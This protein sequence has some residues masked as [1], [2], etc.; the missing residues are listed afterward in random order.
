MQRKLPAPAPFLDGS[1]IK[2][3]RSFLLIWKG[4]QVVVFAALPD[5]RLKLAACLVEGDTPVLACVDVPLHTEGQTLVSIFHTVS[6]LQ[7][8]IN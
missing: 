3:S 8:T 6:S 1:S 2:C 7:I 5:A 4:A